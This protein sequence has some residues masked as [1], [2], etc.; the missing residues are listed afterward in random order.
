VAAEGLHDPVMSVVPSES[1][2]DE[3]ARQV[4]LR[5]SFGRD[6]DSLISL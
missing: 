5:T 2:V 4:I 3:I 6:L 1:P